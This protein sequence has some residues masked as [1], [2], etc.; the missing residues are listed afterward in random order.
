V[1]IGTI[2]STSLS[3]IIINTNQI[4]YLLHLLL[5]TLRWGQPIPFTLQLGL[6]AGLTLKQYSTG[7][8]TP[9]SA[10]PLWHIHRDFHISGSLHYTE[11]PDLHTFTCAHPQARPLYKSFPLPHTGKSSRVSY[12]LC[13]SEEANTSSSFMF[14]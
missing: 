9:T 3:H 1:S 10:H 4:N 2:G 6:Q 8:D 5:V 12:Q 13:C 11:E 14:T 7:S